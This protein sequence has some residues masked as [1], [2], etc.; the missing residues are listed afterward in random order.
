MIVGPL[1]TNC[2][3]VGSE[4]SREG[5]IIDPGDEA[6]K[7]LT[8]VKDLALDIK[9]ILLTHGHFDHIGALKEV[10]EAIGAEVAMHKDDAM[11]LQEYAL[12]GEQFGLS[13]PVP[14]APGR[15]LQDGDSI[16]VGDL[17]FSVLH[18]PG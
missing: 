6:K 11:H 14:P 4:S 10:K 13:Y 1:A 3:I 7:I 17:H 15:L 2:Y 18:T 16:D 5:V 9:F 8:A 12:A